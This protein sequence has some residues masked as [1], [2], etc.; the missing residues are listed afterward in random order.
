MKI[1]RTHDSIYMSENRYK[2]PKE[3]FKFIEKRAF[4]KKNN[5]KEE[6][7]CDFG[8]A[9]GEFIYYLKQKHPNRK[10]LGVDIRVDLLKKAKKILPEVI[11]KRKSVLKKSSFPRN[12]FNKTFLIGVHPIF[13]DFEKCFSNLIYWTKPKGSVYI[14]EMF[15]YY[16]VDVII[17]YR[18]SNNYKKSPYESGWNIFSE[19]SVSNF[20]KKKNSVKNFKF[21]KFEMT[22]DLK[23]QKDPIRSWTFKDLKKRRYVT[24]GLSI[25]QPQQLL[26]INLK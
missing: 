9:A 8:C 23:P 19:E 10:F 16:P 3:M 11:F 13:D 14:C 4:G 6:I 24:N 18:T 25:I 15:N 17:K 1:V 2:K 22:F 21:E 5:L 20:L 26:T 7:I 12:S